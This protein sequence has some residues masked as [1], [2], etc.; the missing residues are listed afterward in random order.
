MHLAIRH[1]LDSWA[2][3]LGLEFTI[4]FDWKYSVWTAVNVD[5]HDGTKNWFHSAPGCRYMKRW[6]LVVRSFYFDSCVLSFTPSHL[7]DCPALKSCRSRAGLAGKRPR[8][9]ERKGERC[10]NETPSGKGST[11]RPRFRFQTDSSH[12]AAK[13]Q[14]EKKKKRHEFWSKTNVC[15]CRSTYCS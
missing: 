15:T 10:E 14:R 13:K 8:E 2:V 4:F 6:G 12:L 1:V 5:L 7:E 9:R 3:R 11:H